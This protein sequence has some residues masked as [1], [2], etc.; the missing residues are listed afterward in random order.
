MDYM[1][2]IEDTERKLK[3]SIDEKRFKHS[4]GVKNEA[5]RMA[6]LFGASRE[7]AMF[8][9]ILHDCAKCFSLAQSMELCKEHGVELDEWTLQCPQIVHAS[10]GALTARY[11]YG[12]C[13]EEILNAIRVHTVAAEK[14]SLL[15]KIIYVADMAEPNRDFDG[16]D[17]IRDLSCRD[18]D[19]AY[20]EA[21]RVS[22]QFNLRKGNVIHPDTIYA[23]NK[24]CEKLK[25]EV[26]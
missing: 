12:I 17:V 25:G 1:Y 26:R 8:A 7:K 4:I 13:D 9:G 19:L 16:I 14:M 5:V 15:D 21:I 3:C 2:D 10:V 23:W 11:E 18:I 22:L 20:K 24:I 6:E